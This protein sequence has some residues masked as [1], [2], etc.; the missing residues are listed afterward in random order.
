MRTHV[1]I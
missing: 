1:R